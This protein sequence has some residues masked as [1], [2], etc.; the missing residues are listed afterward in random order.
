MNQRTNWDGFSI[1]LT[2]VSWYCFHKYCKLSHFYI[3]LDGSGT[4]D[5]E[6]VYGV[7]ITLFKFTGRDIMDDDLEDIVDDILEKVDANGD[8]I[9]TQHE[10]VKFALKSTF[11]LEVIEN[12]TGWN[13]K[14]FNWD[15]WSFVMTK[16]WQKEES[17]NIECDR[18]VWSKLQMTWISKWSSTIKVLKGLI[19]NLGGVTVYCWLL[20]SHTMS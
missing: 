7:V 5:D 20:G 3:L 16:L 18:F 8:G 10:F 12:H 14:V 9:I 6:E 2:K 4:I 13:Y 15:I 11:L 19:L 17:L 1:F